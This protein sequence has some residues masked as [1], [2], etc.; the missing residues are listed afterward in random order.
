VLEGKQRELT[1][2]Y[3]AAKSLKPVRSRAL[4]AFYSMDEAIGWLNK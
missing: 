3:K 2:F 4:E 1:D